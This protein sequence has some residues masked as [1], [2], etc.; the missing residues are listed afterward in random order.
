MS[1]GLR[2]VNEGKRGSG[3]EWIGG[4]GGSIEN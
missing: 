1:K 2:M 3:K 4:K